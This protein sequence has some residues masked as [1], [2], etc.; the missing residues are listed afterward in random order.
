MAD[1]ITLWNGVLLDVIRDVGK[2]PG[3]VSRGGAMMHGAVYDAVNSIVPA[4]HRPYLVAVPPPAGASIRAAV[5]HAAHDTLKA[6]FPTTTV[7]LDGRLAAAIA[8][9][10]APAVAA[11][12]TVGKAAAAAMIAARKDDG[13][14][15][16]S[17]YAPGNQPGDWRP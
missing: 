12:K 7:D 17:P 10:S 3:P 4:T 15:D 14:D 11:G 8:G 2:A 13:A 6:A 16:P 5:A 1:A 9:I